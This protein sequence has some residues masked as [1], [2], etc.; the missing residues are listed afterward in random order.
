MTHSPSERMRAF[1]DRM[2][3]CI[4]KGMMKAKRKVS[5]VMG[6]GITGL[7]NV[8]FASAS[9]TDTE[10]HYMNNARKARTRKKYRNRILR[11]VRTF[12]K[13]R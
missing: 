12:N 13:R 10:L 8:L 9:I 5:A 1:G 6:I 4:I 3:A 2:G 11:R 7:V